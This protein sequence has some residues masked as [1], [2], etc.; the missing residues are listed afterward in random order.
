MKATLKNMI[1]A[2]AESSLNRNFNFFHESSVTLNVVPVGNKFTVFSMNAA[3]KETNDLPKLNICGSRWEQ[4][5]KSRGLAGD[6]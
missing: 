4:S 1:Q 2:E 5:V 6:W 3:K